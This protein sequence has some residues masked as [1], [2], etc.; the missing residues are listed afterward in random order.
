MISNDK[1]ETGVDLDKKDKAIIVAAM[2]AIRANLA[3]V[4][5]MLELSER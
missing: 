5:E 1:K 4:N 2:N 3:I